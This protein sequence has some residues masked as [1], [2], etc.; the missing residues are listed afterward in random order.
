MYKALEEDCGK[1]VVHVH[2]RIKAGLAN[3]ADSQLLMVEPGTP[4]LYFT[5]IATTEDGLIVEYCESRFRV[6]RIASTVE[7]NI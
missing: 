5:N 2:R 3:E 7:L 6:D 1:K 4:L